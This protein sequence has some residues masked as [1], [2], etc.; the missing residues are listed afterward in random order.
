LG[1]YTNVVLRGRTYY[2]RV[3]V[4]IDLRA[5][6]GRTDIWK[7]LRT[8]DERVARQA[9]AGALALL[10]SD[11]RY[12]RDRLKG[13]GHEEAALTDGDI[14]DIVSD[15]Y[16]S[17]LRAD[18]NLRAEMPTDADLEILRAKVRREAEGV[19]LSA[20]EGKSLEIAVLGLSA[21]FLVAKN[22]AKYESE[23]RGVLLR[24]L[25]KHSAKGET[26]LVRWA[27]DEALRRRQLAIPSDGRDY[28]RLCQAILRTWIEVLDRATERDQGIWKGVP[29]DPIVAK[30]IAANHAVTVST[31]TSAITT[32]IRE[33]TID[34]LFE[35]YASENP[36]NVKVDTLDE[37]R[38]IIALFVE[39][40]PAAVFSAARISKKEVREWKALLQLYPVKAAEILQF[41][42]KP[43]AEVIELN[44]EIGKPVIS[45]KSVNKYLSALGAFCSWLVNHGWLDTTLSMDCRYG[46]TGTADQHDRTR[47][48]N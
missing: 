22:G 33:E 9:A 25:R 45:A 18:D 27:A 17:E 3:A 39:A 38:K 4:P 29:A 36:R 34:A 32:A 44:K 19:D 26:V 20:L 14:S 7:S 30:A 24:E 40:L 42:G 37:S 6:V 1:R 11:W 28:R 16:H 12:E 35:R 10:H 21:D 31:E 48:S 43:I 41:R 23:R 13:G 15:F 5:V 2:L 8:S 46:M 47:S